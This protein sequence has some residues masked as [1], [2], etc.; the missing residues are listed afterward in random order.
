MSILSIGG[1]DV[2][3]YVEVGYNVSCQQ[4][5]SNQWTGIDGSEHQTVLGKKYTISAELGHVPANTAA[6]VCNAL[7]GSS[8]QITFSYPGT[9]TANFIAPSFTATLITETG[10]WDISINA[11]SEPQLNSL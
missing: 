2:S 3:D 11:T 10:L 4:M 9:T 6:A 5:V 8:V 1:T 7:S